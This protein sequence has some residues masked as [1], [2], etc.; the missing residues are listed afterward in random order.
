MKNGEKQQIDSK[1]LS[2]WPVI[3][4]KFVKMFVKNHETL[5]YMNISYVSRNTV[6]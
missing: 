1:L 3:E 6:Q 4:N 5:E 2:S